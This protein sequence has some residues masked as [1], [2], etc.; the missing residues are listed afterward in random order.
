MAK[1]QKD[2]IFVTT[3][4]DGQLWRCDIDVK[5]KYGLGSAN[6]IAAFS[7]QADEGNTGWYSFQVEVRA[8][9]LK[10][11]S[12]AS[13]LV[14]AALKAMEGLEQC[15]EP[16]PV[17]LAEWLRKR[18]DEAVYDSRVSNYV[19]LVDV[20]SAEYLSWSD[21]WQAIGNSNP[22][23]AVLATS[24]TEAQEELGKVLLREGYDRTLAK[25]LDK[26]RPVKQLRDTAP[27]TSTTETKTRLP[28]V[29][30]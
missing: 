27:D 17:L 24:E 7:W 20:K 11:F 1:K 12:E 14:K 2:L 22:T 15:S 13:R 3:V 6:P 21:D 9:Y 29:G 19:R 30:W 28:W 10:Q 25:W 26:G 18:A 4:R 8:G 23:L 5:R 16:L